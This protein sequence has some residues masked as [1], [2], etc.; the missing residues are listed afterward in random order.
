MDAIEI[1]KDIDSNRDLWLAKRKS[2]VGSSEIITIT[3]LNSFKTPLELWAEKTGR[4]PAQEDND[5]MRLG[6]HMESFIGELF[7]RRTEKKVSKSSSLFAKKGD[8]W[9]TAS[10]DYY[11]YD[12]GVTE[13]INDVPVTVYN[14]VVGVVECKNVNW[15]SLKDWE[16]DQIPNY[17]YLQTQWQLGVLG[18]EHGH[19]AGLVGASPDTFFTPEVIFSEEL[20][21][22]LLEKAFTFLDYVA[23]DI[24]PDASANDIKLLEKITD[25]D[26]SE[27]INLPD[28]IFSEVHEYQLIKKEVSALNSS[29]RAL[30]KEADKIKA[31]VIQKMGTATTAM[32]KNK[33]I[34]LN[35]VNRK[36]Q[37]AISYWT[38]T[39]K[40]L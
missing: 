33:Q 11:L 29:I 30:E 19:V 39:I 28:Y 7:A 23:K 8:E 18:L 9:A 16:G 12:S 26:K 15:R 4:I 38:F 36:A 25:R 24:P 5:Y 2:T 6:R 17:A 10:P 35:E 20:F 3:G 32:I 34:Y 13:I 37:E 22:R 31:K 1:M 40:D 21:N 14:N 27:V